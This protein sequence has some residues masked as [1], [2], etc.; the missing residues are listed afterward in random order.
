MELVEDHSEAKQPTQ[1][2]SSENNSV[3]HDLSRELLIPLLSY[4]RTPF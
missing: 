1:L 2:F 3:A 4:F